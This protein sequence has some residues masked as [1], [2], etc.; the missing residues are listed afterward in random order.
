M[1]AD[2]R[3]F[4]EG[5]IRSTML[6]YGRQTIDD[7]DRKAVESV[8]K[9]DWLTT[10]PAVSSFEAVL[11]Q[12]TGA[13]HAV[14]MNSGTAALHAATTAIEVQPDDEVIVPAISFVAS[15]NCALY[16][17]AKPVFA[18]I[19]KDTLNIDPVDVAR[20]ITKKTKAIVAVDFAGHPCDHDELRRIAAAH[21]L[22]IISDA[23]HSLGATYRGKSVG[24]LQDITALSFHPVKIITTGEGGALLTDNDE[25]AKRARSFRHHG[26]DIDLHARARRDTF[27]Y[28][29]TSLGFNYRITDI[30]C[31]LGSSQMKKL[32]GWIARRRA[33]AA[34][35]RERLAQNPMLELPTER[36]DCQSAW[37]LY[38]VRF[39]L[40]MLRVGR[41]EIFA[42]MRTENIGVNVHYIP[43]P[44]LT[45]YRDLG[46]ERGHWPIAE[47]EYER[48]L[49]IPIYPGMTDGDV[50]D[51]V[52]ALERVLRRF[53][54]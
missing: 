49:S 26:I 46:Y 50:G 31:A 51:V 34:M 36:A 21:K 11:C 48:M 18:D 14:A 15:A 44:W 27:E 25:F 10:G 12:S 41:R 3:V 23:A 19:C 20:K 4:E 29:V 22:P 7:D 6:P 52:T 38:A 13:R 42:A 37:H 24:S 2:L 53:R 47:T 54:R 32:D 1:K 28:D 17:R 35:Y 33:I 5:P 9:G 8:L 16:R 39:N 30:S 40:D 45:L 43:I